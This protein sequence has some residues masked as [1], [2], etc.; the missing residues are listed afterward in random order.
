MSTRVRRALKICD[1][2]VLDSTCFYES[3]RYEGDMFDSAS[4]IA[5]AQECQLVCQKTAL[6]EVWN[7][8]TSDFPQQGIRNTCLLKDK[9]HGPLEPK[10]NVISGP[11]DCSLGK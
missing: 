4:N 10:E 8:L 6:C 11:K 1:L 3:Q 5:S 7:Y 9:T 2:F